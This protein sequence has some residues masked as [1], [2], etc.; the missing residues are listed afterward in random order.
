MYTDLERTS[1][2]GEKMKG[3]WLIL[4]KERNQ[5]VAQKNYPFIT[6]CKLGRRSRITES[7]IGGNE[8]SSD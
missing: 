8:L 5:Y 7:K 3:T 6:E 1:L 4:Y 2:C